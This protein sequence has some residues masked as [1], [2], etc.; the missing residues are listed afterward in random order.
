MGRGVRLRPSG[1]TPLIQDDDRCSDGGPFGERG[2][3]V[4]PT[5]A[6]STRPEPAT[7]GF[8]LRRRWPSEQS[9]K[10]RRGFGACPAGETGRPSERNVPPERELD[11][12]EQ[13]VRP[14]IRQIEAIRAVLDGKDV[15]VLRDQEGFAEKPLVL[16]ERAA[17]L[18]A[19]MDGEHTLLD[20]Q[21][22]YARRFGD[23]LF[24]RDI[25]DLVRS[26][27]SASLLDNDAFREKKAVAL[28]SYREART[29][30]A[31]H[32]S[33]FDADPETWG[34]WIDG[35]F[36]SAGTPEAPAPEG[37]VL[38]LIVPH[39]DLRIGGPVYASGWKLANTR[40][41]PSL[42]V[43]LGTSHA[44]L[45]SLIAATTKD[46]ETPLGT[47][48]T[49]TDFLRALD[50]KAGGLFDDELAHRREHTIEFQA[51]FVRAL[52]RRAKTKIVPLLCGYSHHHLAPG[53]PPEARERIEGIARALASLIAERHAD[54]LLVA[55]ADL[56][57]VGPRYGDSAPPTHA[58]RKRIESSDRTLIDSILSFDGDK[59]TRR[60]RMTEDRTR[61]CGYAPI[62]ALLSVLGEGY[63]SLIRYDQ[64][65]MGEDGSVV[66]FASIALS[67]RT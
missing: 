51:L 55:S 50:R 17:F 57:H 37:K 48:A 25:E 12:S 65:V 27:D 56:S 53:A 38:G 2:V 66:S 23:L 4:S 9:E 31:V 46:F 34:R 63:G 39:I 3:P 29:R 32:L 8:A 42:V 43:V 11:V 62:H 59:M 58:E 40:K 52:F 54:A 21:A 64:G 7:G 16:S 26:L 18:I 15:V 30:P 19:F 13:E 22:A 67:S 24:T 5:G 44:P 45:P 10:P 20:I 60:L 47:V 35:F 33:S 36:A 28:Q 14:R 6:V 49:D 1:G 41:P 61:I